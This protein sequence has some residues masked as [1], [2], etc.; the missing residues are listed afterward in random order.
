MPLVAAEG[1]TPQLLKVQFSYFS[2]RIAWRPILVSLVL[3]ML[4]NLAGF[5]LLSKDVAHLM[6]TRLHVR[7]GE[8]VFVR[9]GGVMLPRD[10]ID[11]IVPGTTTHAD[12]L[13]LCGPPDEDRVRRGAPGLSRSLVYRATRRI[14]R[15]RLAVGRLATVARWDEE[16]YELEIELIGDRVT[17][18]QSRVSHAKAAS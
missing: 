15:R 5:I 17:A 10:V 16:Q 14:P 6:R 8:P 3:L 2:G 1:I 13:A 18:V 7:R 11:Q 4:G 12:V 9:H